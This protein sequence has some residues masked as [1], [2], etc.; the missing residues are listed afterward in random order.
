MQRESGFVLIHRLRKEL[1]GHSRC[2]VNIKASSLAPHGN[3]FRSF[4]DCGSTDISLGG[5]AGLIF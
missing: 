4:G 2:R 1:R 5:T 3:L